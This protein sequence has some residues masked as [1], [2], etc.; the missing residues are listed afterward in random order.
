MTNI[1]DLIKY[2]CYKTD[3]L[4]IIIQETEINKKKYI[5]HYFIKEIIQI[6]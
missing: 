1:D 6:D 2:S 4:G 3:S 5:M